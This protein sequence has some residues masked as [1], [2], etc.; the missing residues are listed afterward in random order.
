MFD[1]LKE[2]FCLSAPNKALNKN[3]KIIL[4]EKWYKFRKINKSGL[5][6]PN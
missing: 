1:Y 2:K 4:G 6:I 5:V 3:R